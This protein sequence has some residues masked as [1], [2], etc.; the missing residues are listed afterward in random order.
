[1]RLQR[2]IEVYLWNLASALVQ[3]GIEV[4]I[5]TW[6]GHLDIPS[7]ARMKGLRVLPVPSVRYFQDRF[8][9]PFYIW[10]LLTG[11][12]DH[13]FIHFAGYGEGPSLQ[14][15]SWLRQIDFSVVFHFPPSL[16]PHRYHE[17]ERWGIQRNAR[18]LITVSHSVA[19]EIE[20]WAGRSCS[21][22]E[23]GVDTNRFRPNAQLRNQVR[24]QLGI[25]ANAP[26]IVSAAA[27][28]E[29]KGIQWG[30]TAMQ[31][32]VRE[33]PNLHYLILGNGIYQ[34]NLETLI[35]KMQLKDH[36]HLLGSKMNVHP[37]LCAADIILVLSQ[38][39]ASSIS[40]LEAMACQLPSITSKYP[41][42]DELVS[43]SWGIKVDEKDINQIA[44]AISGLIKSPKIKNKMGKMA[45]KQILIAHQWQLAAKQYQ[46]LI[47]AST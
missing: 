22:I 15:S 10:H 4:D 44:S 16:V 28:E 11:R 29:R 8:A 38:G 36:V 21:T 17:F 13:I 20:I 42:F 12:Y 24:E 31:Q 19:D 47:N 43:E 2:G 32:L 7:Y 40:L 34:K 26:V 3:S 30:I 6:N 33:Y 1:M 14:F 46:S 5:L 37:Y 45:R 25:N 39:E 35:T 41:P 9:I 23:H 18:H 27:L